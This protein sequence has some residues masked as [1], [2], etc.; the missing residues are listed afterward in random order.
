[1]KIFFLIA[2]I[3]ILLLLWSIKIVYEIKL[4][5][6]EFSASVKL[7]IPFDKE[8]F[9]SKKKKVEPTKAEKQKRKIDFE[10]LKSLK[11]P[12]SEAFSEVCKLL[13]KRCKIVRI[14]TSAMVALEDP[15]ENG[16]AYGIISGALNAVS[17]ILLNKCRAKKVTLDVQNDFNS[18]EGL[19]FESKG[20]LKINPMITAVSV[21]FNFKLIRTI[22]NILE[23]LKTEGK[24]N[25]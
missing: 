9:N 1:M 19:I 8:L 4:N 6:F 25:G 3:I 18:G 11:T 22:K 16:I 5:N 13:G 17:G 14:D 20:I 2:A 7:K 24:K 21:L 15:M 12:V 10:T 23:I